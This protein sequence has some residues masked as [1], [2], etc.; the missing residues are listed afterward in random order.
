MKERTGSKVGPREVVELLKSSKNVL[1]C[2]HYNPDADAYG[3][4]CGLGLALRALGKSVEL[5]NETGIVDRFRFIP[6]V[7]EVGKLPSAS[8]FDCVVVCDCGD[9]KRVGD[10]LLPVLA[11]APQVISIDHHS[12]NTLFGDLNYVEEG[13][14][15]TASLVYEVVQGLATMSPDVASA[16]YVGI[17]GDSGSFRYSSTRV[18]TFE[19]AAALVRAG[20][21]PH[22]IAAALYGDLPLR[23]VQLQSEALLNL[24]LYEEGRIGLVVISQELFDKHG[25][26]EDD[27]ED[28]VE[29]VRDLQ[30]V[31]VAVA[32]RAVDDL[33]RLSLRSVA[34][35]LDVSKVARS[36]GGGGH[37]QAAAF[38]SRE[39]WE[40]LRPILL[41]SLSKL[42]K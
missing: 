21:V 17:L 39:R 8:A 6:G 18:E 5:V 23:A 11:D 29:R 35:E 1:L 9:T 22:E 37:K 14:V 28:L 40:D 16:L 36:F 24:Q 2:S 34:S 7:S 20:A 27:A 10:S 41:E 12:S 33:W 31:Q 32:V 42:F 13:A 38:R 15:S 19:L 30:G 25:A 3:S 4:M 26:V